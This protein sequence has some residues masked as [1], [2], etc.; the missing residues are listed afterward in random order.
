ME[1]LDVLRGLAVAGMIL[2]VSPG[3][4]AATYGP[5]QHAAWNGWTLADM[6]F[7][8]FL[9]SVGVALGL[10]FPRPWRT[11]GDR[12][13]FWGR[14]LRRTVLLIALGLA[15]EATYNWELFYT[16]GPAGRPGLAYMRIPGVLQRIALCYLLA[17]SALVATGR[18]D[19]AGRRLLRPGRIAL[20]ALAVLI[21][22]WALLMR[23]PAP[24]FGPGRLDPQAYLG[25][26]IDRR[27]FTVAHLWRLGRAGAD[28]PVVY[29]P[30]GLLSTFPA[31]VNVL[32][33]ALAGWAWRHRGRR[34]IA[35]IGAAGLGL[36]LAGLLLD[37]L[38]P[39]N[40]RIW[41]SSFA[42]FSGG[43]SALALALLMAVERV[44]AARALLSPARVLGGNA[45]LAFILATLLGRIYDLPIIPTGGDY[46]A[47]R[48]WLDL[49]ALTLVGD[50]KA[51]SLACALLFVAMILALLV[52][53]HRRAIH[54]RL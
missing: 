45:M 17:A 52:P 24:G 25:G 14:V 3:D 41:S 49:R 18:T 23:V 4:W 20:A 42:L 48:E 51:A 7:P 34:A 8:S 15:L 10:S 1:S 40:K 31:T 43:F 53:L 16:E 35:A 11:A 27:L 6:V 33:G 37:P 5:L 47:P 44:R 22:Y 54:F 12:R 21:G 28:G 50:A 13:R 26:Y 30:E 46:V 2:V 39:I 32:I 38:F 9:F 19:G 29:D 36:V